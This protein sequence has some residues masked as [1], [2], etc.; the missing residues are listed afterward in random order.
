MF[1]EHGLTDA[2]SPA[3]ICV[4][5]YLLKFAPTD[6]RLLAFAGYSNMAANATLLVGR[7]DSHILKHEL[8]DAY[9]IKS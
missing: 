7:F 4:V 9:T 3:L 6:E 1:E 2:S 8:S 5:R